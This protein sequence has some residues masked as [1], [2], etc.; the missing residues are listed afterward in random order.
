M[1]PEFKL[2]YQ[3]DLLTKT[4]KDVPGDIVEAGVWRGGS[5]AMM[6]FAELQARSTRKARSTRNTSRTFWLYDTFEGLPPPNP[7]K[8][9]IRAV[10]TWRVKI[11]KASRKIAA[12]RNIDFNAVNQSTVNPMWDYGSLQTV[13]KNVRD[14]GYPQG[15]IRFIKGKVENTLLQASNI[16]EQIALLRLDTGAYMYNY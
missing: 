11:K 3:Y 5:S 9:D 16:P 2:K 15:K 1:V 13:T 4:L 8:D 10:Q 14:T 12:Q 7:L 6:M